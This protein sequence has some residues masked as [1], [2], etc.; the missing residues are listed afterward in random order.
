MAKRKRKLEM[1]MLCFSTMMMMYFAGFALYFDRKLGGNIWFCSAVFHLIGF[2]TWTVL[3]IACIRHK[4]PHW[5]RFFFAYAM[6]YYDIMR[7]V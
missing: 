2:A 7:Y 4:E 3:V 1:E 6:F 5:I